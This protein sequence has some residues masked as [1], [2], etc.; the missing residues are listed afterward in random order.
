MLISNL[1]LADLRFPI[2]PDSLG[3]FVTSELL[4]YPLPLD[5]AVEVIAVDPG[6]GDR[7]KGD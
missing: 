7:K 2:D 4:Q 6:Q 3:F 1:T 5:R